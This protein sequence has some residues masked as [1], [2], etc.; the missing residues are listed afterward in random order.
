MLKNYAIILASG[1]GSRFGEDIPKQ[2][3][4]IEGKTIL[5][6]SIEAFEKNQNI[7]KIIVVITP[8]YIDLANDIIKKANFKK[9][10]KVVKGGAIRKESSYAGILSVDEEEANVLIHDCARPFVSQKIISE[11]IKALEKYQAVNVAIPAIDTILHVKDGFISSIPKRSEL[12]YC[13]TPQCF[14]LSLIKHAHEISKNDNEFSDDC[15]MVIKYGLAPI[16]IVEGSSDNIKITHKSDYYTAQ[17]ILNRQS[18]AENPN[19]SN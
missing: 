3:I 9:V 8:K 12:M 10:S 13:Q 4:K 15:G 18:K 5:E 7:D 14:K 17:G 2:F 1:S 11:C 16:Y 6:Y 19:N